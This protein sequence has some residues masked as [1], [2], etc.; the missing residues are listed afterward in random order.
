MPATTSNGIHPRFT[1]LPSNVVV[2]AA[3]ACPAW[4]SELFLL[5]APDRSALLTLVQQLETFLQREPTVDLK[6]LAWTLNHDLPTA[7][8]RLAIVAGSVAELQKR[9]AR[10]RERLHRP[11]CTQLRD[12]LGIYYFEEPLY[13]QGKIA[14]LFPGEGAQ[15]INMAGDL[16]AHFPEVA[17]A[18]ARCD[19]AARRA[20]HPRGSLSRVFQ[21][22]PHASAEEFAQAENELRQLGNAMCSVLMVDY[23]L[24]RLLGAF[25]LSPDAV[26]GHSMGELAA[27][28]A[29]DAVEIDDETFIRLV[30]AVEAMQHA[31]A[32]GQGTEAVL[33]AVGAGKADLAPLLNAH[34]AGTVFLAMDNCPHQ[35]VVVGLPGPLAAIEADLQARRIMHERLPFRR[36]YHTPLF[37]ESLA[38]LRELF[39]GVKFHTPRIPVYS[40]TTARLF[41]HD[42]EAMRELT[43]SH[44]AAP[45]EFTQLIENLYAEGVRLFVESGPRGNLSSFVEDILRGRTCAAL[46]LNVPR[47]SPLTQLQHVLGQLAAHQVPL[48][49]DPLYVRRHPRRIEWMP[50]PIVPS[51]PPTL[52]GGAGA[53]AGVMTSYFEV[54]EQFLDLQRELM[55]LYLAR[56]PQTRSPA[57]DLIV[58]EPLAS[59]PAEPL[60]AEP[61]PEPLPLLGTVI[62]HVPG[63]R[64]VMRRLMDLS[65][66]RFADEH[67]VGGRTVS[68]VDPHQH[69]LPVMPMTFTLEMIAEAATVFC[70]GKVVLGLDRVKLHRWLAFDEEIVGEVEITLRSAPAN[71]EE[72]GVTLL[73]VEVRDLSEKAGVA[74]LGFVR[75]GDRLPPAPEPTPFPLADQ[76]PCR[77]TLEQLYNSL[78]HGRLFT[79]VLS[80]GVVGRDGTIGEIVVPPRRGLFSWT[81]QPAFLFDPVLLDIAM[82]P[83]CG[84]HLEQES[85]A[86]RILLP[87]EMGRLEMFGGPLPEGTQLRVQGRIVEESARHYVHTIEVIGPNGRLWA[88]MS[89]LKYWRFYVPFGSVNF[90]GPKD[91]YFLSTRWTAIED[92]LQQMRSHPGP[93]AVARLEPPADLQRAGM[94]RAAGCV[95]L[96]PR[97]L[98][99]QR[100]LSGTEAEQIRWLFERITAKDAARLL[101]TQIHN[102]RIFP[103]DIECYPDGPG[104]W[105]GARR[106]VSEPEP[107]PRVATT[108]RDGVSFGVACMT[109]RPGIA[110][111]RLTGP[112]HDEDRSRLA[113]EAVA[114]ALQT[115]VAELFSESCDPESGLVRILPSANLAPRLP[116]HGGAP[117]RVYTFAENGYLVAITFCEQE[118]P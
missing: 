34:P 78:F 1:T 76:H 31:E 102:E 86:G 7:G 45:V 21:L 113:L 19:D 46:P 28:W 100:R 54:M 90:H 17:D 30:G 74:A 101:W 83:L 58:Q 29:A 13:P 40:C 42:A 15:Y 73:T 79:G 16:C 84:W 112:A 98:S 50:S 60:P 88:R 89:S 75:L 4:E 106:A 56:G 48:R 93:L 92:K 63:E 96:T 41:P 66:D 115:A 108:H 22:P 52:Q 118:A 104:Q 51:L 81:D 8:K 64:L 3:P 111:T 38:P 117:L 94:R 5:C 69:G 53:R 35:T 59:L 107:F 47:R 82:H 71:P 43:V 24:W 103:A 27:L 77:I 57:E 91:Q 44:W 20:H 33:L 26:A 25:G 97:E 23:A 114:S 11:D 87:F 109:G 6:D 70:P 105:H 49:L 99:E 12:S 55:E 37:A 68:K 39:A 95:S 62:E 80:L 85:Q 116:E 72:P 18:F 110:A 67:T 9:L 65:R 36:P 2:S 61:A 14:F 10:S 32:A